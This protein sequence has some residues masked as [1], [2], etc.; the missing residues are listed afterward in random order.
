VIWLPQATAQLDQIAAYIA[1]DSPQNTWLVV[2]DLLD[3]GN[4]L[5]DFPYRGHSVEDQP[6]Q[7]LRELPLH[8]YRMFYKVEAGEIIVVA[9]AHGSRLFP[10]DNI[11]Y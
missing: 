4:S 1:Q 11:E 3:L 8:G 10:L 7:Q 9:V 6:T 2:N 5:I